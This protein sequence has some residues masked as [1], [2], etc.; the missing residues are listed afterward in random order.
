MISNQIDERLFKIPPKKVIKTNQDY[1]AQ[2]SQEISFK[3]GDFFYVIDEDDLYYSIINPAEKITGLVPK[4]FC[5]ALDKSVKR[6]TQYADYTYNSLNRGKYRAE[7]NNK[8]RDEY[9][10]YGNKYTIDSSDVPKEDVFTTKIISCG[11][12]ENNRFLITIEVAKPSKNKKLI[13]KR[14][15]DD[16]FAM[17]SILLKLFPKEAGRV[18]RYERII[19]FVPPAPNKVMTNYNNKNHMEKYKIELDN[20]VKGISKMPYRIQNSFPVR[21]F[22]LLRS[23]DT[24]T[25]LSLDRNYSPERYNDGEDFLDLLSDYEETF[26]PL[27]II[28]DHRPYRLEIS[29]KISFDRLWTKIEDFLD[30]DIV[31]VYF[32]DEEGYEIPL[33]NDIDLANFI[34]TRRFHLLLFVE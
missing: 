12:V 27:K 11:P 15:Y 33:L 13:I 25:E 29:D 8:H 31:D 4:I 16:F 32:K 1:K 22:F 10:S 24:E 2:Y 30:L 6:K 21:R 3:K 18:E 9:D 34:K 14:L 5:D 28:F 17:Q 23:N 26:L 19:P 20:Y 7:Y